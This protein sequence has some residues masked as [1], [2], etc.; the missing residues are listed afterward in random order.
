MPRSTSLAF[1][2]VGPVG[3]PLRFASVRVTPAPA[4]VAAATEPAALP[5]NAMGSLTPATGT[6]GA[7]NR[8]KL[9]ASLQHGRGP[10]A[11]AGTRAA[12]TSPME[13][14]LR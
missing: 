14:P 8:T 5:S 6:F 3:A 2:I 10:R 13:S 1:A 11:A 12:R 4:P 9:G 7:T